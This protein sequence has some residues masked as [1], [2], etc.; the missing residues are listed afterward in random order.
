[1]IGLYDFLFVV[2]FTEFLILH[3][4]W[5]IKE[6]IHLFEMPPQSAIDIQ[7]M[8]DLVTISNQ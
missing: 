7:W 3:F 8:C 4:K 1:M 6:R 5:Y 2:L